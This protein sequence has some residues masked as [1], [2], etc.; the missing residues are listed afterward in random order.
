MN[1]KYRLITTLFWGLTITAWAADSR[2]IAEQF[3]VVVEVE[4]FTIRS[5]RIINDGD[6]S[7]G[8]A[9]LSENLNFHAGITV[10]FTQAGQYQLT[11]YEKTVD[12]GKDSIHISVNNEPA[13]RTYPDIAAYGSY[14]PCKKKAL[15][16]LN[17]PGDVTINL[18]TTNEYGSYYD[19]VV[20][21]K[22]K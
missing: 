13:I 4:N 20:I 17:G 9:V 1:Q 15:L 12:G 6:A 21:E 7:N 22:I 5:G 18:Y 16:N 3:P 8:K 10:A 11:V 2:I 14:G 19:K